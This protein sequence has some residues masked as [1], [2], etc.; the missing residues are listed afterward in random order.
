MLANIEIINY[1]HKASESYGK[2]RTEL[3]KQG[4][5][6]GSLEM[7]IAAHAK[8][9]NYT[10]VTNNTKEFERVKGLKLVNWAK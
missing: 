5:P 9:L 4:K 10:L 3:E 7:L 2:I 1:D 8:S 6:I